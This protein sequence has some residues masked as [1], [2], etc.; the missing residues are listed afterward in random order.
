MSLFSL[1]PRKQHSQCRDAYGT[2][3]MTI[4][5]THGIVTKGCSGRNARCRVHVEGSM[6]KV[7]NGRDAERHGGWMV[8]KGV[9]GG[10]SWRW[11]MRNETW[12][13]DRGCTTGCRAGGNGGWYE[14]RE[15][16]ERETNSVSMNGEKNDKEKIRT[17][18]GNDEQKRALR[19]N[20]DGC[21]TGNAKGKSKAGTNLP[22][23]IADAT[24]KQEDA[25]KHLINT[26]NSL[27]KTTTETD[28]VKNGTKCEEDSGTMVSQGKSTCGK[29]DHH[30][31]ATTSNATRSSL[32]VHDLIAAAKRENS[33]KKK[34]KLLDEAIQ[35][36]SGNDIDR[37][38]ALVAKGSFEMRRGDFDA[39]E[40]L[41]QQ[42]IGVFNKVIIIVRS[43]VP[44][45]FLIILW[46]EDMI[47]FTI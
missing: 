11:G 31:Q 43:L 22:S 13:G 19:G 7:G 32:K 2:R 40:D 1:R 47:S 29:R 39:A 14:D 30:L 23:P 25:S 34:V 10:L 28:V 8:S 5:K 44:I 27:Q 9:C 15:E 33:P 42:A 12:N 17:V 16:Q 41:L 26:Q 3:E 37:A 20:D 38:F 21:V 6:M 46:Y 24:T 4:K 35:C 36:S 18:S 45:F